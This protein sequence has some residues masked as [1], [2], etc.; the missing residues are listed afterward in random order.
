MTRVPTRKCIFKSQVKEDGS[1]P[2]N[3]LVHALHAFTADGSAILED[4]EGDIEIV[5][6]NTIRFMPSTFALETFSQQKNNN[7]IKPPNFGG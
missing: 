4:A 6:G 2:D 5:P 7:I 1:I 3:T